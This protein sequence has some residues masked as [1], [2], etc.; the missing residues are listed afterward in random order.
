MKAPFAHIPGVFYPARAG[1]P[2]PG[3]KGPRQLCLSAAEIARARTLVCALITDIG[4]LTGKLET[5]EETQRNPSAD[6]AA[7]L[8]A[9]NTAAGEARDA[10]F[11]L[12]AGENEL[13]KIL[14]KVAE[15]RP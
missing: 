13:W 5:I 15:A 12:T 10:I 14:D 9:I 1:A 4:Q 11:N 6:P 3:K 8:K 7:D 2:G